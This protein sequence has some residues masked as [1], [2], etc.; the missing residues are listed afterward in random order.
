MVS[1]D[2]DTKS[3][4]NKG[5]EVSLRDIV[6]LV[7]KY[8]WLIVVITVAA[9]VFPI[10]FDIKLI[11]LPS[12][13]HSSIAAVNNFASCTLLPK[14]E[15]AKSLINFLQIIKLKSASAENKGLIKAMKDMYWDGYNQEWLTK[16]TFT[17][18]DIEATLGKLIITQENNIINLTINHDRPDIAQKIL[19]FFL[20]EL[21]KDC[22]KGIANRIKEKDIFIRDMTR[23]YNNIKD[24]TLRKEMAK[25]IAEALAEKK[26]AAL[27]HFTAFEILEPPSINPTPPILIP[28]PKQVK[29]FKVIVL[30]AS[31]TFV[32]SMF[33]AFG[34]EWF[35][36]LNN[37]H[38]YM[39][40]IKKYFVMRK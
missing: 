26:K 38:D 16:P 29:G 27:S 1:D 3:Q 35:R 28:R 39:E 33:L 9:A 22:N 31:L 37:K 34:I 4:H 30:F 23:E 7:L 21:T 2:N 8:K 36:L 32:F 11:N 18:H 19:E 14:D 15:T 20:L 13:Q 17:K 6:L 25:Y 10:I 5:I 24:Q 40:M 12:S